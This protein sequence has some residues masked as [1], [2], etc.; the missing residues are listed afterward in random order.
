MDMIE[1]LI[2]DVEVGVIYNAQGN[3]HHELRRLRR[4]PSR[5]EGMV[6]ISEL[7]DYRVDR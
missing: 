4:N 1:A 6:H 3:T 2:K 7:A 5:Q